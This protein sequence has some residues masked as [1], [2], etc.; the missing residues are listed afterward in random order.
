MRSTKAVDKDFSVAGHPS[1][2]DLINA[3]ASPPVLSSLSFSIDQG[4]PA[5]QYFRIYEEATRVG[6]CKCRELA[7]FFWTRIWRDWS[8]CTGECATP[9]HLLHARDRTLCFPGS[10]YFQ[11]MSLMHRTHYAA[12]ALFHARNLLCDRTPFKISGGHANVAF[13]LTSH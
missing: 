7:A 6:R 1:L 13:S 5:R 10:F 3:D 4:G 8:R 2:G 9:L 12:P 11:Q